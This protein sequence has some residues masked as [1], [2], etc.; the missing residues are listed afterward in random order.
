M[1]A[2][3]QKN[4]FAEPVQNPLSFYLYEQVPF[5]PKRFFRFVYS[6]RLKTQRS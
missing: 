6:S 3:L 4:V 2:R 5:I 1:F